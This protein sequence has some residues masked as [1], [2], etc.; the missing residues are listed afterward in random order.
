VLCGITCLNG[1]HTF[2]DI[3]TVQPSL[4]SLGTGFDHLDVAVQT[5]FENFLEEREVNEALGAFCFSTIFFRRKSIPR[6]S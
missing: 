5:E 3:L 2:H 6:R 1:I 4:P